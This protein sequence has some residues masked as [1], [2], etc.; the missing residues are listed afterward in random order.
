[1]SVLKTLQGFNSGETNASYYR[2]PAES[3]KYVAFGCSG[4]FHFLYRS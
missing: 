1:M 4:L 3:D 2:F